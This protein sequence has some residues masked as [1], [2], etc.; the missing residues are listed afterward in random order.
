MQQ[1]GVQ[2]G[3][4]NSARADERDSD[5]SSWQVLV[6]LRVPPGQNLS[7]DSDSVERVVSELPAEQGPRAFR[8]RFNLTRFVRDKYGR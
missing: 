8:G 7:R 1:T 3:L 6:P 4:D 2:S 5:Y